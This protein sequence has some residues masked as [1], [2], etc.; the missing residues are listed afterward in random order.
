[1]DVL[2]M[3]VKVADGFAKPAATTRIDGCHG[4]DGGATLANILWLVA[5][6]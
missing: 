4:L 1:M 5:I 6:V 2:E 3:K